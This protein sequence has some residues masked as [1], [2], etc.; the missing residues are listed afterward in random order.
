M[1]KPIVYPHTLSLILT[2]K[3][4]ASCLNCCFKCSPKETAEIKED[5]AYRY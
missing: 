1:L 2:R 4:S 5:D 3:C